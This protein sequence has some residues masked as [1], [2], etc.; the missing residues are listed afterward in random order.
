MKLH[1]AMKLLNNLFEIEINWVEINDQWHGTYNA[2][3]QVKLNTETLKS[4]LCDYSNACIQKCNI[5]TTIETN[6][7][8]KHVIF[9]NGVPF[10]DCIGEISNI[11]EDNA[12]YIDNVMSMYNLIEDGDNYTKT[13]S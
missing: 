3:S 13:F 7:N 12:K 10:T 8:E 9:K 11:Q 4:S 2:N 1:Y 5:H 6:R